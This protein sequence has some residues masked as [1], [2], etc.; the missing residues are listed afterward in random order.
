MACLYKC[1]IVHIV[2]TS[3]GL[4]AHLQS[5]PASQQGKTYL[6]IVCRLVLLQRYKLLLTVVERR[7]VRLRI[8]TCDKAW[9][10]QTAYSIATRR[11]FGERTTRPLWS[12]DESVQK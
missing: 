1:F 8:A 6:R 11:A 12:D 10:R 4:L 3:I 5:K 2:M 9:Q 7:H